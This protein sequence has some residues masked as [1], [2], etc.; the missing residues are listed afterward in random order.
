LTGGEL[1]D[2]IVV[3][4]VPVLPGEHSDCS[5]EPQLVLAQVQRSDHQTLSRASASASLAHLDLSVLV[6]GQVSCV[7]SQCHRPERQAHVM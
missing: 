5:P 4:L 6:W 3:V 2:A 1:H 7:L